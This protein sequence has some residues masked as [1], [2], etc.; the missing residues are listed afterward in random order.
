MSD[1]FEFQLIAEKKFSGGGSGRE[2]GGART[3]V[4]PS[5][6]TVYEWDDSRQGWFPKVGRS[7]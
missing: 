3:Y 4:D 1:D 2:E 5:D 6:G 7:N